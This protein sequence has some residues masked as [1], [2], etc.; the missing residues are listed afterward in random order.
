MTE[1]LSLTLADLRGVGEGI[2]HSQPDMA[3]NF[4]TVSARP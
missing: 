4:D 1:A 2:F 3:W